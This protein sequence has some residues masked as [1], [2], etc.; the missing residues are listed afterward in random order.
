M[1]PGKS[2]GPDGFS[3]QSYK[4]F[5]EVLHLRFLQAFNSALA[6]HSPQFLEAHITVILKGD[7]DLS[8][9]S[10]YCPI[11]L[12]NVD[13]KRYAK[14]L[15]NNLLL[16]PCIVSLDQVGLVPG[17]EAPDNVLKALNIHL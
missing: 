16:L 3:V 9:M 17:R 4:S 7:Q 15:V 14:A 13:I 8:L 2:P 6:S 1:K 5:Y 11:S 10:N 12:L